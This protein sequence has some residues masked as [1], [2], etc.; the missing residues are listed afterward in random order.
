[1]ALSLFDKTSNGNHFTQNVGVGE[2]TSVPVTLTGALTS[3]EFDSGASDYLS[4]P[5]TVSL[6]ITGSLSI[7]YWLYT[8]NG[9]G[10]VGIFKDNPP[11]NRSYLAYITSNELSTMQI[12]SDGVNTSLLAQPSGISFD[13]W[14]HLAFVFDASAGTA[15]F[16]RDASLITTE[17]GFPA[18]IF[19]GNA[20]LLL[21]S[22]RD[23]TTRIVDVR[24]WNVARTI[25]EISDNRNTFY[26]GDVAGLIANWQFQPSK[27]GGGIF[28]IL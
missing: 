4:I 2:S 23:T 11:S 26:S 13:T 17:T 16:Y 25:T 24:I 3:A 19:N 28:A 15:K 10:D 1:M 18:S 21:R 8:G 7:E 9:S 14:H 12:S 27:S 5:H 6:G 20:S 22:S